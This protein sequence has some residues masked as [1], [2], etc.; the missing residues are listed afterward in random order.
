MKIFREFI[1]EV[2]PGDTMES[3]TDFLKEF[4]LIDKKV[5]N[6]ADTWGFEPQVGD[7]LVLVPPPKGVAVYTLNYPLV[8]P[9]P[10]DYKGTTDGQSTTTN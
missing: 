4:T 3:I 10:P 5:E 1:L 2:E 6:F 7:L 9:V 8:K